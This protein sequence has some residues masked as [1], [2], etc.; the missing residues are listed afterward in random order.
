MGK[1][2]DK[3]KLFLG[4]LCDRVMRADVIAILTALGLNTSEIVIS[5][6]RLPYNNN[7]SFVVG[8]FLEFR[9][10]RH[11]HVA[12]GTAQTN[13]NTYEMPEGLFPPNGLIRLER[14][15]QE[16]FPE[17]AWWISVNC[18]FLQTVCVRHV[19][20]EARNDYS[21][22]QAAMRSGHRDPYFSTNP[23]RRNNRR[24]DQCCSRVHNGDMD[25]LLRHIIRAARAFG[26]GELCDSLQQP[27]CPFWSTRGHCPLLHPNPQ[28]DPPQCEFIHDARF[29]EAYLL[30]QKR[31][32]DSLLAGSPP[33][34]PRPAESTFAA[35][36]P[37][38]LTASN[39]RR[40]ASQT[41]HSAPSQQ[42]HSPSSAP[43]AL[44][45]YSAQLLQLSNMQ[46]QQHQQQQ[47]YIPSS[48]SA[49]GGPVRS[50]HQ[51]R[52]TSFSGTSSVP[53][54]DQPAPS[55]L[56]AAIGAPPFQPH[57]S[58]PPLSY[59]TQPQPQ[60]QHYQH[61]PQHPQ[62]TSLSRSRHASPAHS[63]HQS[64]P[65]R[66][67]VEGDLDAQ[68][69]V[70]SSRSA[71]PADYPATP[72]I[73]TH[74]LHGVGSGIRQL[75]LADSPD[76]GQ[77]VLSFAPSRIAR[78]R[79]SATRSASTSA[80]PSSSTFGPFSTGL[81]LDNPVRGVSPAIQPAVGVIG[82]LR[83]SPESSPDQPLLT[84][85][86]SALPWAQW[87]ERDVVDWLHEVCPD[88]ATKHGEK[89]I[90]ENIDGR[91]L[92]IY[93]KNPDSISALKLSAGHRT[94]FLDALSTLQT[95][96]LAVPAL[97]GVST[98]LPL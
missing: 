21:V 72:H 37:A 36:G 81:T 97:S 79:A 39:Q 43:V 45:P 4:P 70:A 40:I 32:I 60:S 29:H 38:T 8:A 64:Q 98:Q 62:I 73:T 85:A 23:G 44:S 63:P 78:A 56:Q 68:S 57:F 6:E 96:P 87:T 61:P 80:V 82:A 50:R 51:P 47:Q 13:A 34:Q 90:A 5:L 75:S 55:A 76:Q 91:V 58:T 9:S 12:L 15:T 27:P 88:L 33:S 22:A 94:R 69:S 74:G 26:E 35:A 92:S 18:S 14:K 28:R 83:Q 89:F 93:L 66:R 7:A 54:R 1:E 49:P 77:P 24:N 30:C 86:S 71:S 16:R 67:L 46:Q 31:C 25:A 48:V 11:A 65:L 41:S 2:H 20:Q 52:A 53:P 95:S 59:Q 19:L 17:C 10:E 3:K 84:P 42:Q